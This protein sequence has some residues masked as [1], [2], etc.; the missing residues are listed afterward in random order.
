[1]IMKKRVLQQTLKAVV[2]GISIGLGAYAYMSCPPVVGSF[3]FSVGILL[4]FIM[5]SYLYTGIVPYTTKVREIPFLLNVV[6]GNAIG[7]T[8][9]LAFDTPM[10][11]V[12]M[13]QKLSEP[14]YLSFV[15]AALCGML[16]YSAVEAKKKCNYIGVILVVGVFVLL[17]LEHSIANMCYMVGARMFTLEALLHLVIVIIGNAFGGII[18]RKVHVGFDAGSKDRKRLI[19]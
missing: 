11:E 14:L 16:I 9:M 10:A 8:I 4:V 12:I 7:S 18:S 17:G 1:M 15:E 3:V 2:A 6:L 13:N 19:E 5:D